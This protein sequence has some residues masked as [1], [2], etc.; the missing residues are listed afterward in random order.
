MLPKLTNRPP[1]GATHSPVNPS[2]DAELSPPRLQYLPRRHLSLRFVLVVPFLLQITL[3]VGLT[4]Y[5]SLRNGQQ[6]VQQ[7]AGQ[8]RGEISQR[9]SQHLDTYLGDP[10][11]INQVNAQAAEL[12][13]LD[14][15]NLTQTG[16]Y[17]FK[18]MQTFNVGYISFANSKG[19]SVGI[20]RQGQSLLLTETAKGQLHYYRTNTQGD[21]L[22][23]IQ[24]NPYDPRQE[25]WFIDAVREKRLVWSEI[26]QWTDQPD[27]FSIAA[28]Y[29]IYDRDRLIGV[30]SVDHLLSQISTFLS[31]IRMSRSGKILI[32][33]RDGRLVAGSDLAQP[34]EVKNGKAERIQTATSSDPLTSTTTKFLIQKFGDLKQI[35]ANQQLDFALADG[36]R[37]F[38]QVTPWQ[39]RYGLDWL[40]VV[41]VPEAAFM[42]QTQANTQMTIKL[43]LLALAVAVLLGLFTSKWIAHPI[44]QLNR[45]A[46][47]IA[48][49]NLSQT[50]EIK[51]IRE[52]ALLADSFNQMAA[53]LQASFM[54]LENHNQVLEARVAERTT[55]LAN[56]ESESRSLLEELSQSRQFLNSIV[57][58]IPLAV[59]VK[60][61]RR[62]FRYVLW[63]RT[64]EQIYSQ[65]REQAIGF[66][67]Y[68]WLDPVSA[69]RFLQEDLAVIQRGSPT[70]I[71]DTFQQPSGELIHQ[72]MIKM[73]LCNALGEPTHILCIG[74]NITDRKCMETALRESEA[75]LRK[76]NRVLMKLTRNKS[77]SDGNLTEALTAITKAT[78]TLLEVSRV[79]I[80]LYNEAQTKI[81]CSRLYDSDR[82][83][84]TA[85]DELQASDYPT[86]F[87]ALQMGD[88]IIVP[89][90]Q[91]D[92]LTQELTATYLAPTNIVSMLDVPIN[93]SGNTAGAVCLEQ[94]QTPREWTLEEESFVRS[95]ADLVALALEA[96]DRKRAEVALR[97]EQAKSE[98]L[99]LNILPAPIAEQLKQNQSPIAQHFDEVTILFADIVDFTPL[100]ARLHPIALVNLLNQIFSQFDALAEQLGLEKIKTI[101]D[102][103]M[104]AA[105][106]PTPRADHAAA[107]AAMALA[108]REVAENFTAE[109]GERFQ[110]RVGLNTGVAVAG[111]IGTKKFIYDLWGDAVNVASRMESSGLPGSIQ[112]TES[113]YHQIKDQ[114]VLEERG[115]VKVKGKGTMNT[116]WLT[117]KR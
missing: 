6:A 14:L 80:W 45:A 33:E 111:V 49:G 114:Y 28:N 40:I 85:G 74:E 96:R 21:R 69:D 41:V 58:N 34:F 103:Y 56:A 87:A 105:G 31:Q 23:L 65:S 55:E 52:L 88:T 115:S 59:F 37:Q 81:T 20:A 1:T 92:R 99:L 18:Q 35:R 70:F 91:T 50:V 62:E 89:A 108:M 117:G 26:Y 93:L 106:L 3:A 24:A 71:E 102:A 10:I 43:C 78:A 83:T 95:I 19:D 73:P 4:G 7:V 54:V 36:N 76:Q 82:R 16:R 42:E 22:G 17:F 94:R 8:W 38:L 30:L 77:L 79:G 15:Q 113:T 27:V 66:N 60:D 67:S 51:N 110:L 2:T 25:T 101:G 98:Q 57:E 68:D 63:N 90:A 86:Y 48:N 75:R 109:S 104:V 100:S 61:V 5:L 107:A 39:D 12:G 72:R 97:A 64:A 84:Y 47:S 13:L 53:Q 116:Y 29:P 44:H 112:V 32:L 9:V 11:Q 46:K